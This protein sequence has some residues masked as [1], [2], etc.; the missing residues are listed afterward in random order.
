MPTLVREQVFSEDTDIVLWAFAG[1]HY[2][3][4]RGRPL[5]E[6]RRDRVMHRMREDLKEAQCEDLLRLRGLSVKTGSM[7]GSWPTSN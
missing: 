2:W 6:E 7:I 3:R 5:L 1:P 4:R